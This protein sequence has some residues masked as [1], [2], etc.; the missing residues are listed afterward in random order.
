MLRQSDG[1]FTKANT[2]CRNIAS[3]DPAYSLHADH[4]TGK[5]TRTSWSKKRPTQQFVL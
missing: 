1:R 4:L 2:R 3:V 5:I